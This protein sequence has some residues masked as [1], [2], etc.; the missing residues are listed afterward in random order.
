MLFC[1]VSRCQQRWAKMSTWFMEMHTFVEYTTQYPLLCFLHSSFR[2]KADFQKLTVAKNCPS[3]LV[4]AALLTL[5]GLQL[6]LHTQSWYFT[7]VHYTLVIIAHN[8]FF[9]CVTLVW[10][11]QTNASNSGY[12]N[13]IY[14]KNGK[15]IESRILSKLILICIEKCHG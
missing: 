15:H 8:F 13:C 9:P 12:C 5:W 2:K 3:S 6:F 10:N 7:W 14:V 11:A 4:H 1:H